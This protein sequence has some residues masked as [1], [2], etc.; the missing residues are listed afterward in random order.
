MCLRPCARRTPR[1]PRPSPD[2]HAATGCGRMGPWL[3]VPSV[4]SIWMPISANVEVLRSHAPSAAL[5]AVVKA[6]AYGHGLVPSARAAIPAVRIGSASRS[7]RRP[8]RCAAGDR[9]ADPDL[10]ARPWT[11]F[12]PGLVRD[13]SMSRPA[14]WA[15]Q[16][17]P[18]GGH[19]TGVTARVQL[20][21]DSGLS[22]N[23]AT[24]DEW[25]ALVAAAHLEVDGSGQR[26]RRLDPPRRRRRPGQS[27][28][29]EQLAPS[30]R[31]SRSPTP[32]ACDPRCATRPTLPG[33]W[34][35][36]PRGTTSCGS[37]S[38]CTA[39][40]PATPWRRPT[41]GCVP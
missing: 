5:L 6:D 8:P 35:S 17:L 11:P 14:P 19:A 32:P 9:G 20:K 24:V 36:P 27:G 28:V 7:P 40:R 33:R 23:G 26:H 1:L 12:D 39:C 21:L 29:A 22:R 13:E 38:R 25:P 16:A 10:A 4:R 37:A 41:S 15:L 2:T 18:R 31:P 30:L 34:A 3:R